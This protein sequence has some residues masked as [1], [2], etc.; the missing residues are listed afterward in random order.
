MSGTNQSTP[1]VTMVS[2][3]LYLDALFESKTETDFR[4]VVPM[5]VV[6]HESKN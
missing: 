6:I 1:K 5:Q 3:S 2:S 4:I